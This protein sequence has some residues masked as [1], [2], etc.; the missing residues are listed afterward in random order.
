MEDAEAGPC[1]VAHVFYMPPHESVGTEL[2]LRLMSLGVFQKA[3]QG[4]LT[5]NKNAEEHIEALF[6]E[7]YEQRKNAPD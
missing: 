2:M 6:T 1:G 3:E 4:I 5:W 7:Y